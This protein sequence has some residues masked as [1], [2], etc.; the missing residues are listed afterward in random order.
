MGKIELSNVTK[1]YGNLTAV[2]DLNIEFKEGKYTMILGPSGC[3]KSTTLRMIAGLETPTAG[4]VII[5]DETVTDKPPR[6]RDISMVFQSLALW[7]HK[8]VAENMGFG[9]KMQDVEK[10][11]RRQRVEE[12]AELLHIKDKLD[13]NPASLSGGQQQRV[14]LGRS[15]VREPEVIL[16]D[17][18]LSSLDAKLRLEM[19]T[20]L[21]RIQSELGTTFIHVTHNQEDAMTIADEILLLDDGEVQQFAPSLEM[22]NEPANRFVAD[23]IGNPSINMFDASFTQND[24]ALTLDAG[25]FELHIEDELAD[26]YRSQIHASEVEIGIRPESLNP[27]PE[28]N[29][30]PSFEA[31]VTIIETFGD[32]NWY[33]VEPKDGA[34]LVVKSA[35]ES[36]MESLAVGDQVVISVDPKSIHVF[37]QTTGEALI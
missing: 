26:V 23:F 9:L 4:D 18:P 30:H 31:E 34:R 36:V 21:A 10:K 7:S 16:L 28:T 20:E 19:R 15:L 8:T 1:Q 11:E 13:D 25:A 22:Y 29:G 37:D 24:E 2:N 35:N 12:I 6:H 3:G 27:R 32:Q 17:E 5:D 33:Y 14:A